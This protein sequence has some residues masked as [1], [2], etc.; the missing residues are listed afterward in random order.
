MVL[1]TGSG[2]ETEVPPESCS[3]YTRRTGIN[4]RPP[5]QIVSKRIVP[6]SETSVACRAFPTNRRAA[7]PEYESTL[8]AVFLEVHT[9]QRQF[10]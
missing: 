6:R 3:L 5:K 7:K 9:N 8:N 4:G 1:V 2:M 10:L